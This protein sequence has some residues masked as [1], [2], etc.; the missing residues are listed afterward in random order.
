MNE[1][2]VLAFPANLLGDNPPQGFSNRSNL[3]SLALMY[4]HDPRTVWL[5]RSKADANPEHKQ[6]IVYAYI[7]RVN[8]GLREYLVYERGDKGGE[9]RLHSRWSLGIGGHV[10][11]DRD[12]GVQDA[13]LAELQEEMPDA[14]RIGAPC[15]GVIND[16]SD[17]VGRVHIGAVY[18]VEVDCRTSIESPDPAILNPRWM[19]F[20]GIIS[21]INAFENWSQILIREH[22][23]A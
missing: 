10:S 21:E 6:P 20:R 19:P 9:K 1:E 13:F 3:I 11:R 15:V 18:R 16:D 2:H 23:E 8:Q 22:L 17:E 7:T 12:F 4:S 14:F 5:P